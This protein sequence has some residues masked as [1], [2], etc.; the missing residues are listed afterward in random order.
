[1]QR[2]LSTTILPEYPQDE[3]KSILIEKGINDA[4]AN[5]MTYAWCS[6]REHAIKNNLSPAPNFRDLMNLVKKDEL[7]S[8]KLKQLEKNYSS[9]DK[10]V[11]TKSY[12]NLK[13]FKDKSNTDLENISK[14]F[15]SLLP[16]S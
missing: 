11:C 1:L 7:A 3:I 12:K 4:K 8:K 14:D 15:S 16:K 5:Q 13:F 10:E 2:R 6:N 9:F